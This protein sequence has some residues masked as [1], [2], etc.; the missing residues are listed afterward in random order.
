[1][2]SENTMCDRRGMRLVKTDYLANDPSKWMSPAERSNLS[3]A[4]VV[5]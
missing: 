1:M 2:A 4:I 5:T 3:L